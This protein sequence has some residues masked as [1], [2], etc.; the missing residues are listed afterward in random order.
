MVISQAQFTKAMQEI[1]ESY[2]K[3]VERVEKLERLAAEPVTKTTRK[4][5]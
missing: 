3:L 2:A 5:A 1:N 4:A